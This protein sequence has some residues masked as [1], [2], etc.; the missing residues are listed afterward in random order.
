MKTQPVLSI[1]IATYNR[2]KYI[3][4]TLDSIFSQLSGLNEDIE[5]VIV[6]GASSD[7]TEEILN[8]YL[9]NHPQIKY[10]RLERKGGVDQD[11]CKAVEYATGTMCWLFTD[12][13]LIKPNSIARV[14]R[15]IKEGHSLLILNSEVMNSNFTKKIEKSL[16]PITSDEICHIDEIDKLFDISIT[17]ISFIGCIV[18][19][20]QLWLSRLKEPYFGSE[21]IHVGVLFQKLL[22]NTSKIIVDPL[23]QIRYGNAQWSNRAFH[24]GMSK[25]PN[26]LSSFIIVD[27]KI[28][29]KYI[30]ND[31]SKWIVVM[32]MYRAK[33]NYGLQE[34]KNWK[35]RKNMSYIRRIS[36]ILIAI[37]PGILLN[38]CIL[39]FLNIFKHKKHLTRYDLYLSKYN[40]VYSISLFNNDI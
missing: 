38:F 18:I 19:D 31:F 22:L 25:W 40:K 33:G 13:D 32:L 14:L 9:I 8:N 28:R 39:T 6:D 16:L 27:E 35:E 3:S 1:C 37:I 34:F 36:S 26:I 23:I 2:A 20:R 10:Y 12:D 24:I 29:N 11:Y 17:Y 7:N 21:F 30:F 5:I 15:E 4:L